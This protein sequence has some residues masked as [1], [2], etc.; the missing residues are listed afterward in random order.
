MIHSKTI[1]QFKKEITKKYKLRSNEELIQMLQEG[2]K[3]EVINSLLPLV[4]YVVEKFNNPV[5]FEELIS[6]GNM[7]LIRGI[8]TF[9]VSKGGKLISHCRSIIKYTILDHYSYEKSFV[10][11]P[12]HNKIVSEKTLN[13]RPIIVK[14][15]DMP[16]FELEDETY[17]ENNIKREEVELLLM[18]VPGIKAY[19]VQIFL[20]YFFIEGASQRFVGEKNGV[21]GQ[22]ISL[23]ISNIIKIIKRN[24]KLFDRM[25]E[26]LK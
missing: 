17:Y 12:T 9:D 2:K 10:R 14:L 24:K 26:L 16:Y 13:S 18:S 7:G 1:K 23:I 3:D 6:M 5:Y 4:F 19:K 15:D 8:D 11:I 25:S 20:D 21:T 22:N